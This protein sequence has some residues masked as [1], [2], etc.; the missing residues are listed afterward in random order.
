MTWDS[1]TVMA[2]SG[3]A[4]AVIGALAGAV[5]TIMKGIADMRTQIAKVDGKVDVVHA[6]V[7]GAAANTA[8]LTATALQV[9]DD[10]A[11]EAHAL[12]VAEGKL[13]GQ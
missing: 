4:V 12:G 8:A 11:K 9:S 5:V 13:E 1:T 2:V 10:R 6:A 3:A 7:N